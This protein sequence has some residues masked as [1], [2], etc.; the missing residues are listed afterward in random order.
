MK[1]RAAIFL[2]NLFA[3]VIAHGASSS[4]VDALMK[5]SAHNYDTKKGDRY[6]EEFLKAISPVI[7]KALHECSPATPDTK[8]PVVVVFVVAADGRIKRVVSSLNIPFGNCMMAKLRTISKVPRPPSDSWAVGMGF[9]NHDHE[10]KSKGPPDRTTGGLTA[11]S[12]AAYDRAIAPYV[13]KAR[14]SYPAA[15]KRF[16]AGLPPG[17]KFSVRV[18]LFDRDGKREDS[19]I[20]VESIKNEKVTGII[21]TQ[22][23]LLTDYKTGQRITFPESKIDNWVIVRPDGTEEGNYVGKFLDHYKPQ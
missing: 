16:L 12:A 1:L 6:R 13:A 21:E 5:E 2:S 11:E 22:L 8:E 7:S 19:F 20:H 14:A 15:K 10:E 23:R 4:D 9:A 3:V 18:S 17:H